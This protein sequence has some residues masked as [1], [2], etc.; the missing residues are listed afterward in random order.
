M[1]EIDPRLQAGNRPSQ[2]DVKFTKPSHILSESE[3][4]TLG[5]LL[6]QAATLFRREC[7]GI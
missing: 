7:R 2:H 1:G 6:E 5:A 4:Q 3:R